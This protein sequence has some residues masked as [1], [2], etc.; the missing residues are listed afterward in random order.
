VPDDKHTEAGEGSHGSHNGHGG[1]SHAGGPHE[2]HEGA[3]EWLISFADNV[4]LMMGFFVI[5]LAMNM[6]SPKTYAGIGGPDEHGGNVDQLDFVLAL[7]EA[8]NPID[9]ESSNPTEAALRQRKREKMS[10]DG[11]ARQPAEHG[12][13]REWQAVRPTELSNLGGNVPF[14]DDSDTVSPA[15]LIQVQK[16]AA[17]IRGQ[18]FYVDIRGHA[19]PSE[20][21]RNVDKGLSLSFTRASAVAHALADTGVAWDQMRIV[22]CAD[23][24]RNVDRSYDRDADRLNQRVEI[25]LTGERLPPPGGPAPSPA[26]SPIPDG[27]TLAPAGPDAPGR[28]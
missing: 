1:G 16:I 17:R 26:T 14:A 21:Y 15:A 8:F 22:A 5:L 19:S 3:P 11:R 20:T 23:H 9:L 10:S 7:R 25:V 4:A 27:D 28:P 13:A 6:K 2:E 24:E 12:E 18:R